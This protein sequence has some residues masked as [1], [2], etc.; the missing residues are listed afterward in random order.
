MNNRNLAISF[1]QGSIKGKGSHMFVDGDVMY[2]YGH[3]FPMAYRCSSVV[4]VNKDKYSQST[5]RHQSH[6]YV[7]LSRVGNRQVVEVTTARLQQLVDSS[8]VRK[9]FS[10]DK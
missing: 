3:H 2:S 5:T 4:Y 10:A 9:W 8:D 7:A 6:L 1:A